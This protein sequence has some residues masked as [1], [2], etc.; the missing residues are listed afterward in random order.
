MNR[1][2]L[3]ITR[4]K[5]KNRVRSKL[6]TNSTLPRLIVTRSLNHIS[7]QVIDSKGIVQASATSQNQSFKGK[8]KTD[9]ATEIGKL[10]ATKLLKK[11][12][13]AVVLDRG[14]YKYHGRVKALAEAVKLSKINI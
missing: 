11:E 9:Q 12:I 5:R 10:I 4:N 6:K 14:S 13:T 1:K 2:Q 3:I 7:A 8:T